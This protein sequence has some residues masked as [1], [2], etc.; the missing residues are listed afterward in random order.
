MK[1]LAIIFAA[2]AIADTVKLYQQE[3]K[4]SVTAYLAV[5]LLAIFGIFYALKNDQDEHL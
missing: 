2:I 5:L 3:D 1:L 4:A